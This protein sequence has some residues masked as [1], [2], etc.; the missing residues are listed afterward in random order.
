[1][2]FNNIWVILVLLCF[3]TPTRQQALWKRKL[4][5]HKTGMLLCTS[6]S[7]NEKILRLSCL[8]HMSKNLSEHG[9][10]PLV[11]VL[12][13]LM[14]WFRCLWIFFF[15]PYRFGY[16]DKTNYLQNIFRVYNYRYQRFTTG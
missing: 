16:P 5:D 3:Q 1:M 7:V 4:E 14:N 8:F 13:M 10:D 2:D 11:L 12:E 15:F 6:Y 9:F